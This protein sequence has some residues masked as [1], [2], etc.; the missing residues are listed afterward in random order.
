M[1]D[2]RIYTMNTSATNAR[3]LSRNRYPAHQLGNDDFTHLILHMRVCDLQRPCCPLLLLWRGR[4]QL[5]FRY[6]VRAQLLCS[7]ALFP[8]EVLTPSEEFGDI[9]R[10]ADLDL[11]PKRDHV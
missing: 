5:L 9:I 3:N 10:F 8:N 7:S 6:G 4:G 1:P 11:V 2:V